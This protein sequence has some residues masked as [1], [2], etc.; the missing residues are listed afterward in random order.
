MNGTFWGRV[1]G[2][3]AVLYE[4]DRG[5]IVV[6]RLQPAE[7]LDTR[8]AREH[9]VAE[10]HAWAVA[11]HVFEPVQAIAHRGDAVALVAEQSASSS[12]TCSSSSMTS[13]SI[14]ARCAMLCPT[15]GF[16]VRAR[17]P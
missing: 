13:T 3:P 8:D 14:G 6:V 1:A 9:H 2:A 5:A 11:R 12:A 10:H 4:D 17:R 16:V 15:G 7:H